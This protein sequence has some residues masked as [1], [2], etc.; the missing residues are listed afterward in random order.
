MQNFQDY[1]VEDRNTHLEH[2]ED[3]I[4]N[5]G[6]QGQLNGTAHL[7]YFVAQ[8]QRTASSLLQLSRYSTQLLKLTTQ[9]QTLREIMAAHWQI[10]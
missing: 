8:I 5:N 3:E 4:I 10:N 1:I 7:L 9:T 6:S 2:L